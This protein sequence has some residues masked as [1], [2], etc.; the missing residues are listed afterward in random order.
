MSVWDALTTRQL[1]RI[2]FTVAALSALLF[3]LVQ[4]RGTLLLLGI[5]I[6]LAVA[7]GPAVDFFARKLPRSA[8]ILL[9]YVLIFCVFGGVLSLIVPPVINGATDLSRDIPNYINDLRDNTTIRNF[10]NKYDIT[11]KL[12][13]QAQ[14][15]PEKL[16]D[17]AGAL[18]S[19]AAGVV[20]TAFQLLTILTMTFFLLLDGKRI[21]NFLITRFG[22]HREERLRG[23]AERIYKSTSGYVAGALTITS[24]NGVL[25]FIILT[26]L[27]VP[28]AVPLAVLMSF[29]GLIPL[30]GATIGGVIILIVTLF[31]DFPSSTIVYGIFLI[32]YQQVENNVLQP[33]I[34]KRTVN[35]PP[36]AVIVAILAGS[37]LLGVVG[38]LVAI[39]IAAAL[40]IVLREYWGD[41]T[42]VSGT[43]ILPDD[44]PPPDA[45]G[46]DGPSSPPAAAAGTDAQA[47]AEARLTTSVR[48]SPRRRGQPA[49]ADHPRAGMGADHGSDLADE[50]RLAAED[51]DPALDEPLRLVGRL[52]VLHAPGVGAVGVQR[53]HVLDHPLE[54]APR[55]A[56]AL[57]GRD[58]RFQREDRL[59]LQR[60]ADPRLRAADAATA[61]QVL[62]RVEH[63]PDPQRLA[64]GG[65]VARRPPAGSRR[66]APR[67]RRRAA[68]ARGRRRR[69]ASRAR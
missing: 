60:A 23:V 55:G 67:R 52:D 31:N 27:G 66:R 10:D 25:T 36:L 14:K 48:T 38:A 1:A 54:R 13:E 41:Q 46:S 49:D 42:T 57:D 61:A 65:G 7:L 34:F 17:A 58:L 19:I 26:I 35:V 5:A 22:R 32:I 11:S 6:F 45:P 33:F 24:I 44:V 12:Q 64:G 21:A 16:G 3:L 59:D 43:V 39:P 30:V 2:L 28:F 8:S 4:I 68:G 37:A 15:L 40:Q 9:V 63:E 51:L 47:E 53:A 29:F 69:C 50:A 18:Q 62:E 20:N 56:H